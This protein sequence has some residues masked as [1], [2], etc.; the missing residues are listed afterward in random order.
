M[1]ERMTRRSVNAGIGAAL[2]SPAFGPPLYAQSGTAV[3]VGLIMA[4][5]GQFADPSAQIDNGVKLYM[6]Q[7]GDTVAGKED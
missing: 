3:K 2:I 7:H 1:S 4:Y 6:K 5:T